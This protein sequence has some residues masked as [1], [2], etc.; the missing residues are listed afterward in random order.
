MDEQSR[1]KTRRSDSEPFVLLRDFDGECWVKPHTRIG[2]LPQEPFIDPE[3]SVKENILEGL[4]EKLDLLDRFNE[5]SEKLADPEADFDVI[6][7]EQAEVQDKIDHFDGW[8]LDHLVE[9]AREA[10]Q[11]PPDDKDVATLSGGER[12]RI[13]LCR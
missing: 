1:R 7:A 12:R 9:I 5:L 10:L 2:Y 8:N 6:L 3:K 11:C 13:A 4:K